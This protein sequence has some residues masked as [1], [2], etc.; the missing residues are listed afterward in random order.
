MNKNDKKIVKFLIFKANK[1]V[2]M[3]EMREKLAK[4]F[5][6]YKFR[7]YGV[8]GKGIKAKR[9]TFRG[10]RIIHVGRTI[11]VTNDCPTFWGSLIDTMLLDLISSFLNNK[12]YCAEL[13]EF[14]KEEHS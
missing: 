13:I 1:N 7:I 14:L 5:P 6:S 4:K 12:K 10:A 11:R 2:D 3:H 9:S 8:L